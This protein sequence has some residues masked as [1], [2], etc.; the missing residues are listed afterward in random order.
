MKLS[1][2]PLLLGFASFF[3]NRLS[4]DELRARAWHEAIDEDLTLDEA[5]KIV[6]SWYA[7]HDAVISPSH[8]N[9]E[10]RYRKTSQADR[11]RSMAMTLE[12]ERAKQEKASPEVVAR[13]MAEIRKSL[14]KGVDASLEVDS[15][16]VAPDA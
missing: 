11:E 15:G 6:T 10:W 1:E 7:N 5:K 4:V 9:R 8:I 12:Y 16:K 2:V 13:Y 3:D 14:G